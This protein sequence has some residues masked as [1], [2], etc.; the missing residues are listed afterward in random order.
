MPRPGGAWNGITR[1]AV[2]ALSKSVLLRPWETA[3]KSNRQ[4]SRKKECEGKN[5]FSNEADM[6]IFTISGYAPH[7]ENGNVHIVS[8]FFTTRE[9]AEEAFSEHMAMSRTFAS[10]AEEL[11]G[12]ANGNGT[13][14]ET[15][16]NVHGSEYYFKKYECEMSIDLSTEEGLKTFKKCSAV[17]LI[18]DGASMSVLDGITIDRMYTAFSF[19]ITSIELR[20]K[21]I[22]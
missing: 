1:A 16:R 19:R 14:S 17:G 8:E 10:E 2:P 15:T 21:V 11:Q 3:V 6:E 5:K 20:R 18:R 9:K 7:Y 22:N 13:W 12:I 4:P